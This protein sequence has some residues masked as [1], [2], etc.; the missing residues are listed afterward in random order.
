MEKRPLGGSD[1]RVSV[2]GLG[3]WPLGGGPGWGDADE[4]E[5][6]ATIH[7]AL[8]NGINF[9]DTAEAYGQGRSEEIVGKALRGRRDKAIIATKISARNAEPATLRAHCEAS[10]RR[11][12]TDCIDLY[13]VH[14]PF[15]DGEAQDAFFTLRDLG[16]E[17]K[18]RFIGVSNT[19]PR[20]SPRNLRSRMY[21]TGTSHPLMN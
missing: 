10:L 14:W 19:F 21:T 20:A 9:F 5:S 6:I 15:A 11:L 7:A 2:L 18:V 16:D 3:C 13:Q 17:G 1:L 8:D 4:R 12:Q